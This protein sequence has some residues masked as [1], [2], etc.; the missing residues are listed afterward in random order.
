[1]AAL[2]PD[3]WASLRLLLNADLL[4]AGSIGHPSVLVGSK[5]TRLARLPVAALSDLPSSH[6]VCP[7]D[8]RCT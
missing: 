6:V 2:T 3:Q 5:L 4:V 1:M 7:N 8:G